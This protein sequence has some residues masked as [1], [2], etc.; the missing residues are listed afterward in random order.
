MPLLM[1]LSDERHLIG[2]DRKSWLT[3]RGLA[4]K[5]VSNAVMSTEGIPPQA[6]EILLVHNRVLRKRIFRLMAYDMFGSDRSCRKPCSLILSE[7]VEYAL[8]HPSIGREMVEDFLLTE[9]KVQL[10]TI[11]GLKGASESATA[12][13]STRRAEEWLSVCSIQKRKML[14]LSRST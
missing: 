13:N 1:V 8:H 12:V 3:L 11:T 5:M 14:E 9:I 6:T 2:G 7:L 4:M 10:V